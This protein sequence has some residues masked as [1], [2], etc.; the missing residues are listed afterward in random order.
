MGLAGSLVAACTAVAPAA[1]GRPLERIQNTIDD[2][3]CAFTTAEGPTLFVFGSADSDGS[4][5]GAFLE[6]GDQVLLGGEGGSLTFG[7][8]LQAAVDMR[9]VPA[10]ADAGTLTV[11]A[12]LL[13]GEPSVQQV[14]ERSGNSWTRGT[15]TVQDYVITDV[16]ADLPGYTVG[17]DA[18]SCTG[19][20]LVFDVR[21]T[22]PAATVYRSADFGS[23]ICAVEGLADAEIRLSGQ[24]RDPY[25]EIV[26]DDGVEP[27]KAAG[28]LER[29]GGV[30]VATLPLT[31]LVTGE[32]DTVLSVRVDL[33]RGAAPSHG[34]VS[35]DG[36]TESFWFE[37]YL[38]SISVTDAQG[39][40]G[41]A[42]CEAVNVRSHV[43]LAPSDG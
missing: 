21:S 37:P 19:Q 6:E 1:A 40:T 25:A 9:T 34:R 24:L 14:D 33:R 23:D 42:R 5:A 22:N 3:S 16:V 2:V 11:T 43:T 8:R 7:D 26:V 39:G 10:G 17:I 35:E 38:A 32:V 20:R 18:G 31:S 36:F 28:T 4:G 27:R 15:L 30:W 12:D 41:T 29:S 13:L